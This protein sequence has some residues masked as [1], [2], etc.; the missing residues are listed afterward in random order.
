[1]DFVVFAP[2]VS[3]YVTDVLDHAEFLRIINDM[4][5]G[6]FWSKVFSDDAEDWIKADL[7]TDTKNWTV[8][9]GMMPPSVKSLGLY[10]GK[11]AKKGQ[12]VFVARYRETHFTCKFFFYLAFSEEEVLERVKATATV[13]EIMTD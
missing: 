10:V 9:K 7:E 3:Q 2:T 5:G 4:P 1:M 13:A 8:L 12:K 11:R 6:V